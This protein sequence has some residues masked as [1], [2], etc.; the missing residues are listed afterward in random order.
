MTGRAGR[1]AVLGLVLAALA[2]GAQASPPRITVTGEG[3]ATS[4]PDMATLRLGVRERADTADG[5]LAAAS[6]ATAALMAAL[7]AAGLE[8]R[9]IQTSELSLQPL[10]RSDAG[11]DEATLRGFEAGNAVTVRIRDL[12]A[13][14]PLLS[15]AVDAGANRFERLNFG[16]SDP[17]GPTDLAHSRAVEEA[18]RKAALLAEAAGI[19]LPPLR[20]IAE[21]AP[22]GGQP[23]AMR[24]ADSEM[25][26]GV[27]V[28][29]GE[30]SISA[31]V[32]AVFGGPED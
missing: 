32:T 23:M 26:S 24:M 9:D 12:D 28:A 22:H 4:A 30:I 31:R 2:A 27:P 21:E 8:A 7:E 13:L 1:A 16:L 5:A 20:S 6:Q 25:G 17:S 19:A 11:R 10:W 14:G 15:A 18:L 3:Q 29:A